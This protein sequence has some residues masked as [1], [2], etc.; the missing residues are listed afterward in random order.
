ML[1]P[2]DECPNAPG[3]PEANGCPVSVRI[4]ESQIRILQQ[5][6]FE[7]NRARLHRSAIPILEEVLSVLQANQQIHRVR[8]EGHTDSR[9]TE[10]YNLDLSQRRAQ[11]VV[12]WLVEH[13]VEQDRLEPRGFGE[14]RPVEDN[15]T[16][17][18][19][20]ANR[21]VEFHIIDPA[22]PADADDTTVE[23]AQ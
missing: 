7:T 1:D 3:S 9:N 14:S 6:Q 15:R 17:A 8:I 18:G 12:D 19:R 16:R 23:D 21:R 13:G 5:I 2:D 11:T 4:D 10:E 22:P 20:Y